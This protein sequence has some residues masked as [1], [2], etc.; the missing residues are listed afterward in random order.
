MK[1]IFTLLVT[2]A[3]CIPVFSQPHKKMF[4][5]GN[6]QLLVLQMTSE[7]EHDTLRFQINGQDNGDITIPK[8]TYS[9]M[10]ITM[11][12]FTLKGAT[13]KKD[14]NHL[15]T[16]DKEQEFT[17]PVMDKGKEK[18]IKA[19][20]L[21]A[22][23]SPKDMVFNIEVKFQYGKMP[24]PVTYKA[25]LKFDPKATEI[26]TIKQQTDNPR[27]YDLNG[28]AIQGE[29]QRGIIIQNGKKILIK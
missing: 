4:F 11:Q 5:V 13:F 26:K 25:G 27:T 21:S 19:T 9:P 23:F 22:S 15:V 17:I 3:L 18:T 6:G 2:L 20:L 29:K 1:K 24:L 7:T 10:N 12:S 14:D 28:K 8:L 16:F